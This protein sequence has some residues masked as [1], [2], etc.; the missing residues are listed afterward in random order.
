MN[1]D[2][3]SA[4]ARVNRPLYLRFIRERDYNVKAVASTFRL[5]RQSY[6]PS[7]NN[8]SNLNTMSLIG[9]SFNIGS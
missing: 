2:I 1:P 7:S 6:L 8:T 4:H 3:H 9:A 5:P